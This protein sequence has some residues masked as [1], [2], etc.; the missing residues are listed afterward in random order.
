MID[1]TITFA[2]LRHEKDFVAIDKPRGFHVHQPEYPRRRVAPEVVCLSNLRRQLNSFLFPVHRLDV[3][4]EGVLIFA[5]NKPAAADFCRQFQMGI[6]KKTYFAMV[7]GWP[8][9]EGVIDSPLALDSTGVEVDARSRFKTHARVELP[10][11][12]GKRHATSRYALVEVFPETGRYHQVR[13]HMARISHPLL[14]DASHG[15]SHH[16][17]FFREQLGLPGLWLKAKTIEFEHPV[18]RE[19]IRIESEWT[20]RWLEMFARF[21]FAVPVAT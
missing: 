7:R 13:R 1:Q 16:N 10:N 5:L 12:V 6:V 17:R 21:R 20:S 19:N 18:E 14:G 15:D 8:D 9:D 11:A 4:T 2:I 3:A